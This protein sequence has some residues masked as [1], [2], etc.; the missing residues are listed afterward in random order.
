MG[1]W[2]RSGAETQQRSVSGAVD[3]T[4]KNLSVSLVFC[5][6]SQTAPSFSQLSASMVHLM[7]CDLYPCSPGTDLHSL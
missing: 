4:C 7:T 2:H 6:L 3:L 1:R 5:S